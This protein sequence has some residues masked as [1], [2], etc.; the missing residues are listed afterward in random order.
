MSRALSKVE[1]VP[2]VTVTV[3]VPP[4]SAMVV[5]S[6]S[7]AS[8]AAVS[9]SR[10]VSVASAGAVTPSSD[11]APETVTDLSGASTSLST[12]VI[13]TPPVL[14]VA[15]DAKL[16]VAPASVKSLDDPGSTARAETVTVNASADAGATLAVTLAMP[17]SSPIEAGASSSVT[18]GA[19]S[20]SVIVTVRTMPNG[21]PS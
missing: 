6:T 2:V 14:S 4:S 10:I 19:A 21:A 5:A 17:P 18:S 9:S 15:P 1:P 13:V 20:S 12:A 16:S 3:T 8:A 11:T 7:S